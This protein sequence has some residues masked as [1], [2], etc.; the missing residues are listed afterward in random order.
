MAYLIYCTYRWPPLL[1]YTEVLSLK[2][3][4][5]SA[6]LR[7]SLDLVYKEY[8]NFDLLIDLSKLLIGGVHV[9]SF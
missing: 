2:K 6:L 9:S 4:I 5:K 7:L 3:V 8:K 1:K